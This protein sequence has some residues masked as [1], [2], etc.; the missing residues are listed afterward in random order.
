MDV[1]ATKPEERRSLA[2]DV[3]RLFAAAEEARAEGYAERPELKLQ[4]ELARAFVIAQEYFK[5][6][7][8]A[9]VNDPQQLVSDAEIEAFLKEP[10]TPARLDAFVADYVK[11][12]PGRGAPVT[13]E[14]RREL[15]KQYARF[16]LG[17]RKG[18]AAGLERERVVQLLVMRQQARLLAS[19]YVNDPAHNFEPTD[20]EVDAY[21]AKHPELDTKAVR[22]KAEEILRRVR[23][24][25][26]FA[27]L[28][29]QF[30]E[31][32]GSRERGGDL[33]WFGRG[34]MVK[35]FEDAA[36]ALK[37]GEV[38]GI[39][40]SQFGYHIIKLE[41]RRG[42]AEGGG[43]EEVHARHILVSYPASND[44]NSRRMSPRDRA[45]ASV[46]EEKRDAALDA[47]AVRRNVVVAEDYAVGV[48]VAVPAGRHVE[49][50]LTRVKEEEPPPPPKPRPTPKPAPTPKGTTPPRP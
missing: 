38:S 43:A 19:A 36:F 42:G 13:D 34:T 16:M 4:L 9:G 7:Q 39:V 6:R 41:E 5:R 24:G 33:G 18:V 17:L 22:A 35:P 14:Q 47:L 26:D 1:L 28:A 40:E 25:E 32:P 11:N 15:G 45:R 30:S 10:T 50:P 29:G 27:A 2:R 12:G 44:P 20:A 49:T 48:H 37:P 21:V 31:D 3:R 23:A 8:G 46:R